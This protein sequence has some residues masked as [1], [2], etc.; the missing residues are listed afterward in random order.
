MDRNELLAGAAFVTDVMEWA[1]AICRAEARDLTDDEQTAYDAGLA[2]VTDVTNQ[3]D[4]MDSREAE[5]ARARTFLNDHPET[6]TVDG[7]G[8][9]GGGFNVNRKADPFDLSTVSYGEDLTSRAVT[10]IERS[11]LFHDDSH[12]EAATSR[13]SKLGT[14]A[15]GQVLA[16]GSVAYRSA[17]VKSL[18]GDHNLDGAERDAI[19]RARPYVQSFLA[20]ADAAEAS[21]ALNVSAVTGKLVPAQLDPTIILTNDGAA[22]PFRTICRVEPITTNVWTGVSS[23][24]VNAEWTGA[25]G[26]ETA[27]ASPSFVN[28]SVT[29]FMNDAFMA[30]SYQ[31]FDD[32]ARAE[33]EFAVMCAEAFDVLEEAAF[34]TGAGAGSFQPTGIATALDANTNVEVTMTTAGS[35]V[36]G[37]I[38]KVWEALP[39]RYRRRGNAA[40]LSNLAYIDRVRQFGTSSNYHGFTVD[41][42]AD[43]LPAVLGR[44]WHESTTLSGTLS[45]AHNNSIVV[46]DFSNY[47]IADRIG[48]LVENIPNLFGTTSGRPILRRGLVA[49]RR[50]GGGS[51]NDKGFRVL[52]T[53]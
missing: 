1:D 20:P 21:R 31:A 4:R 44:P 45:T 10:A 17:F 46:G 26:T 23:A 49:W 51:I 25:E 28:P 41:L 52:Q 35:F 9:T 38:Y 40:W 48:T 16:T 36:I 8:A 13:V 24:G 53:S 19:E 30:A 39:A 42:T 29:A 32:W 47:V 33:D 50:T 6:E 11:Q 27:D 14:D 18:I 34:A 7:D 5:I 2:Y 3:V 15:A 22:N 37:D 12:R 43:G